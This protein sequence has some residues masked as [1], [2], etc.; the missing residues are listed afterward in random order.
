[1]GEPSHL[2]WEQAVER[3][4]VVVNNPPWAGD[5]EGLRRELARVILAAHTEITMQATRI[6]Q[7]ER[8]VTALRTDSA[9]KVGGR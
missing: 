3:A 6:D 1:M 2:S 4:W 8:D 9:T 7:L 5:L